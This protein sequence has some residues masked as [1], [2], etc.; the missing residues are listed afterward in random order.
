MRRT[1]WRPVIL[2][3]LC[4]GL[5]GVVAPTASAHESPGKARADVVLVWSGYAREAILA[6]APITSPVLLGMA[7]VAI[8]DTAVALGLRGRPIVGG[9]RPARRASAEAAVATAVHHVLVVRTPGQGSF[10][11][12]RYE[13]YLTG[14]PQS[15]A[16]ARGIELGARVAERVLAW[17]ADDGLDGSVAYEQRPPGPGVWEPTAPTTP[18]G[19]VFTGVRP[20]TLRTIDQFRPSGPVRLTSAQYADDLDETRRLGRVDSTER[21]ARQTETVHFWSENAAAQWNRGVLRLIRE[22]NLSLG[23][24]ARLLAAVHV[25]VGDATLACFDAKYHYRF[26]RPVQAIAR[27]DTDG[28][29]AT[30]P[31]PSWQPLLNVNHPEYPSGH[32]CLSGAAATALTVFLHRDRIRFTMDSPVT[33]TEREYR[34]LSSAVAEAID[35]RVWAGLHLRHS[36]RDG[37]RLGQRV[38]WHVAGR[39]VG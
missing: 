23:E 18:I 38:A 27:A 26:W 28:N 36:M 30:S 9:V 7:H 15:G 22:R 20:M 32:A 14:I 19:L 13:Q 35:A 29:P 17:R 31:D 5:L 37:A 11:D 39:L 1:R 12:E 3:A 10:L 34:S 24:A 2:G 6:E 25:A 21:T 33:G 8:Y 4:V 16:K